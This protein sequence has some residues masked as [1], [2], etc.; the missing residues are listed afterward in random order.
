[1]SRHL[2][3][4]G[5]VLVYESAFGAQR[6]RYVVTTNGGD[7]RVFNDA[8]TRDAWLK[9]E[10]LTKDDVHITKLLDVLEEPAAKAICYNKL[11][12][13][14]EKLES[15][16]FTVYLTGKGNYRDEVATLAPYKGNRVQEKPVHY[17]VCR[18]WFENDGAI[19][20]DGQEADDAIGIA[21][22]MRKGEAIVV[23]IDKDLR[24]IRGRHYEWNNDLKY[25][26]NA[27]ASDRWFWLQMLMG[28]R[29]DNI[30]GIKGIGEV[31]A[32]KLL[33]GCDSR[34]ERYL[35]VQACYLNQYGKDWL[36]AFTE[37][38]RLLWIRRSPQ[39]V[40]DLDNYVNGRMTEA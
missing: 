36:D 21:Q 33:E 30:P 5:D 2:L 26:V 17:D 22:T 13:L 9:E 40:W 8:K 34:F 12:A 7:E 6:T 16:E 15:R 29:T 39:Q 18:Q 31:K 1:M 35:A 32:A 24:Q 4:D 25:A 20:V 38:G 3:I 19:V 10:E 27:D 23:S 14:S 11:K 37:V 28:D